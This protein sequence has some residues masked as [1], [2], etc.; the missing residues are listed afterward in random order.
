MPSNCQGAPPASFL[1]RPGK[2]LGQTSELRRAGIPECGV[3]LRNLYVKRCTLLLL[4]CY[5][6]I[7]IIKLLG[8]YK[9][10]A[11]LARGNRQP[12][13]KGEICSFIQYQSVWRGLYNQFVYQAASV[14]SRPQGPVGEIE[15]FRG[16]GVWG[17]SKG[18]G[19]GRGC[20]PNRG[21]EGCVPRKIFKI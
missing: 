6:I 15:M 5:Y 19:L 21:S 10:G 7:Y 8:S 1:G 17:R 9:F 13:A 11:I 14:S 18:L 12:G 4:Y 2:K 20:I 3:C 16:E